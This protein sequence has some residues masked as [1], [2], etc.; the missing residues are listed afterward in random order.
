VQ[1]L[2]PE[3][4]RALVNKLRRVCEE[5]VAEFGASVSELR[6]DNFDAYFGYPEAHEH[7]AEAAVKAGLRLVRRLA[8]AG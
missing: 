5:V 8:I 6:G 3:D 7:D 4:I 2:D 1:R